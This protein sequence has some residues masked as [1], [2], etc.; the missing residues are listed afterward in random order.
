VIGLAPWGPL[1][2][3]PGRTEWPTVDDFVEHVDYVAQLT[4][5]TDHIGIGTDTSLGTYPDHEHDPWG[6]PRW[7]GVADEYGRHTICATGRLNVVAAGLG[8]YR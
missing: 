5:S 3:K 4:G 7:P 6:E 1:V 8:V 2:L